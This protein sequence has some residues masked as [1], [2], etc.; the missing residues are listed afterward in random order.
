MDSI[1]SILASTASISHGSAALA[2]LESCLLAD[3]TIIDWRGFIPGGP[4]AENLAASILGFCDGLLSRES[5]HFVTSQKAL[6]SAIT[7]LESIL[8]RSKAS[9]MSALRVDH[10]Y[11][12]AYV[13]ALQIENIY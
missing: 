7:C 6:A 9:R 2:C 12:D 1:S 5:D 3:K 13:V 10:L 4:A 8:S 11:C